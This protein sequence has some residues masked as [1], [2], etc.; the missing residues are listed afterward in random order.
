MKKFALPLMILAIF[1]ALYEQS[2]ASPNLY[3]MIVCIVIFIVGMIRLSAKTP[4]KN[5][6]HDSERR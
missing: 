1:G 3:I 4:S 2:K 5:K 6:D